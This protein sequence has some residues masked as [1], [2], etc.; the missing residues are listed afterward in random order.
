MIYLSKVGGGGGADSDHTGIRPWRWLIIKQL[1]KRYLVFEISLISCFSQNDE[2]KFLFQFGLCWGIIL[3]PGEGFS[4]I[5]VRG[6]S[7]CRTIK[8]LSQ[9]HFLSSFT[10]HQHNNFNLLK[11]HPIYVNWARLS[12]MKTHRLPSYRPTKISKKKAPKGRHM[13]YN[14]RVRTTPPV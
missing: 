1:G 11:M 6:C 12:V 10:T 13:A 9:D 4:E 14:L 8:W 5:F 2:R 7:A 3:G